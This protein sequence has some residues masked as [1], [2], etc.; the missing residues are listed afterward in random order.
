M[1]R[2]ITAARRTRPAWMWAAGATGALILTGT[3]LNALLPDPAPEQVRLVVDAD[4]PATVRLQ[5]PTGGR[6]TKDTAA[7]GTWEGTIGDT[8]D[9]PW[10]ASVSPAYLSSTTTVTC[11]LYVGDTLVDEST[12]TG[13][14]GSARCTTR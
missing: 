13:S 2:T 10:D 12:G 4:G 5:D 8:A 6:H 11:R 14:H 3:T 1:T 7:S 9:G